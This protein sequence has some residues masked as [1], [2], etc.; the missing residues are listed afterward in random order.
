MI[1]ST[2]NNSGQP[3]SDALAASDRKP[4]APVSLS[5]AATAETLSSAGADSLRA[6]LAATP[7]IRPEVVARGKELARDVNYPPRAIIED[8]ARLFQETQDLS[9]EA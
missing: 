7:E 3:R 2:S 9:L 5:A 1:H 6:A 8:L 4:A